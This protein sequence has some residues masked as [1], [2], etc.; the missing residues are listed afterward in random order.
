MGAN[1]DRNGVAL[2]VVYDSNGNNWRVDDPEVTSKR[3]AGDLQLKEAD[4]RMDTGAG[5]E[6]GA[7]GSNLQD[8]VVVA[9]GDVCRTVPTQIPTPSNSGKEVSNGVEE[10]EVIENNVNPRI[11]DSP[12]Y[13]S[14]DRGISIN[15][16]SSYAESYNSPVAGPSSVGANPYSPDAYGLS[17]QRR[18][19]LYLPGS[20]TSF[21]DVTEEI[22]DMS[23][24]PVSEGGFCDIYTARMRGE[25][26]VAL[27]KLRL[28]GSLEKAK[29]VSL[30]IIMHQQ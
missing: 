17:S 6:A 16:R 3:P 13:T 18:S 14:Y 1:G 22:E 24:H 5:Q 4:V 21:I 27:K 20:T 7:S 30:L 11:P 10:K 23:M 12:I 9:E 25:G 28:L 26:R 15:T 8:E 19:R 2:E 29:R